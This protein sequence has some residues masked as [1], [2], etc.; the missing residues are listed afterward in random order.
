MIKH[1]GECLSHRHSLSYVWTMKFNRSV[2][3][4][5]YSESVR[6]N[7]WE[8]H[9]STHCLRWPLPLFVGESGWFSVLPRNAFKATGISV[10]SFLCSSSVS[11]CRCGD[12]A[13]NPRKI[14]PGRNHLGLHNA[15]ISGSRICRN[16]M[17]YFSTLY[18]TAR[19]CWVEVCLNF[20]VTHLHH[21]QKNSFIVP[22]NF[23]KI[24]SSVR[25]VD[26]S[27]S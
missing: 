15:S 4:Y 9:R 20:F 25:E 26:G 8:R 2:S 18:F 1:V 27:S 11:S 24:F 5:R 12:V 23:F 7:G 3:F 14:I 10:I 19:A 16:V 6:V 17:T 22:T 13:R 21:S